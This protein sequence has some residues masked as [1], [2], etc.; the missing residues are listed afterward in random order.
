M[1]TRG[2][3]A[4]ALILLW[5]VLWH[6]V[7]TARADDVAT[8]LPTADEVLDALKRTLTWFQ[9]TRV[10]AQAGKEAGVVLTVREEEPTASRA[11]QVA[12]EVARTQ[13]ALLAQPQNAE[14]STLTPA[15]RRAQRRSQLEAAIREEERALERLR[16]RARTGS[17]SRRAE[18][19]PQITQTEHR[20]AV[21]RLRLELLSSLEHADAS[22]GSGEPDLTQQ[23]EALQE[24]VPELNTTSASA[25]A[26][27]TQSAQTAP[28]SVPATGTWGIVRRLLALQ[29]ARGQLTQLDRTTAELV[30]E[31]DVQVETTRTMVRDLSR[32]LRD[33]VSAVPGDQDAEQAFHRELE[34][35]KL[36]G[37]VLVPL[38]TEG[39]LLRRFTSDLELW[40]RSI[41]RE[42]RRSLQDL[43]V[44][45]VGVVI[46]LGVIGLG[47]LA[48]RIAVTRYVKDSYRRRLL[49]RTRKIATAAAV[50]LVVV[51]HFTNE[52][53][54]LVTA[55]GFAAAGVAF[56]LQNVIL[57]VAGYFSMMS[58]HGIRVG[59][60]VSL[61]G[62][63]GYVH[64]EVMEIGVVRI[65]LRELAGETLEPTGRVVVFPNSV[66]FTGSFFKHPPA[67]AK[68]A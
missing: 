12:F 47:A 39:A 6:G 24:S 33:Q 49:L 63:F 17:R 18:L 55:L 11:V 13:A 53:T 29:R 35:V 3:C 9:Q 42:T 40:H 22:L 59:D 7:M 64:G 37:A 27:T 68:A 5:G 36:L 51:F 14:P 21:D 45:L 58:P 15:A 30:R 25:K 46:A 31:V 28:A 26:S 34:R 56:A 38:R 52:L 50:I 62:P 43:A 65:R 60:R 8:T 67:P 23:I 57:S 4:L 48:W 32:R 20:L 66:V 1:R 61:Q 2:V 54:A 10:A 44:G 16:E 41:D 19:A